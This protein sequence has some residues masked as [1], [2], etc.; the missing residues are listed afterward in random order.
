MFFLFPVS[1]DETTHRSMQWGEHYSLYYSLIIPFWQLLVGRSCAGV[2]RHGTESHSTLPQPAPKAWD[3]IASLPQHLPWALLSENWWGHSF[4]P[5]APSYLEIIYALGHCIPF[6]LNS[7]HPVI[8]VVFPFTSKRNN[9][10]LQSRAIINWRII[11][12]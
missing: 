8:H 9:P 3:C 7:L 1:N 6:L 4:G 12:S 10:R 5:P 2:R 11:E